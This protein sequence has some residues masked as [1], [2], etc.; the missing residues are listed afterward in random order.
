MHKV[1]RVAWPGTTQETAAAAPAKSFQIRVKGFI[2][3]FL[4]SRMILK[5]M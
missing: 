5:E 2:C 4:A 3:Q 1:S